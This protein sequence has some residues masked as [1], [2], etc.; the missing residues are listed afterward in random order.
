MVGLP[1]QELM[2]I[3]A[4]SAPKEHERTLSKRPSLKLILAS[5][6]REIRAN[7]VHGCTPIRVS[8]CA[9]RAA[10]SARSDYGRGLC[11]ARP[12]A[13]Y[14]ILRLQFRL[15]FRFRWVDGGEDNQAFYDETASGSLECGCRTSG[16]CNDAGLPRP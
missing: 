6:A 12:S 1:R 10:N 15:P 9:M 5:A 16:S 2:L 4:M 8:S 14:S 13:T 7:R 3:V 11:L